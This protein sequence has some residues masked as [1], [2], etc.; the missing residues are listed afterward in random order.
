ML[1]ESLNLYNMSRFQFLALA[2]F[3]L[4]CL[5]QKEDNTWITGAASFNDD[6][7]KINYIRFT[8]DT[9][10][11]DLVNKN[12][13]IFGT[14]GIVS[15]SF[16]NL[17]CYT[18]GI[19][20][21]NKEHEIMQNGNNFQSAA[22]Y[23]FGYPLDQCAI[24]LPMPDTQQIYIMIDGIQSDIGTDIVCEKLRYSLIDMSLNNGLGK[25]IEKKIAIENT[26]DTINAGF[27]NAIRHGNGK[28][29]WMLSTKYE[30][31]RFR[32]HLITSDGIFY[33]GE[34]SVGE[35]V[36]NGIGFGTYSPSGEWYGRYVLS[37]TA[38][39]PKT[40]FYLYRFDRCSGQ[41]SDPLHKLYQPPE[42]Y[43]GVAF[44]P[45]SRFL[46]VAKYTKIYQYDLNADDILASESLVAEYD[47]FLDGN[48]VPTRFFGLLLAPDNKIYGIVPGF[49]TR[50]LHVIDQPNLPGDSCNVIQHAVYLPT[51]NF[52][53]LPNVP[54]FRLYATETPCDSNSSLVEPPPIPPINTDIRVWP[55]P[56]ADVLHFSADG[57]ADQLLC[58]QVFDAFGR[59]L[60]Q[61]GNI[62]LSP[63][64]SVSL[65]ALPSGAYFYLLQNQEGRLLKSGRVVKTTH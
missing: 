35:P 4:F 51:D 34:Q 54:F 26:E 12:I 23:P 16:G 52:G 33:Q 58:L 29:W 53:T 1:S 41:L 31:N 61:H 64:Y 17:L 9:F 44:S 56:A 8:N 65:D 48:G 27:M 46:Y 10:Q 11:V 55:V 62:R 63:V 21:Y 42:Y 2:I 59:P 19:H 20:V 22:M 18:N 40:G 3:P 49:N 30:T 25:V 28:D 24:V 43:G 32:K 13:P 60:M 37:G 15:D 47:G 50:Y 57:L 36:R 39:N 6:T 5:A 38:A 7:F 45:N 14:L